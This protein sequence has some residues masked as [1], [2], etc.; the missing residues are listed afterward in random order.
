ML[1]DVQDLRIDYQVREG[2]IKSVDGVTL[3]LEKGLVTALI[4][5]SGSGKSTLSNAILRLLPPNG[6]I[7]PNSRVM[8]DGQNVLEM[9]AEGVRQFRW[10][11]ASLVFQAAQNALNPTV[12]IR[13]QLL[14]AV[15]DHGEAPNLER[16]A[17]LLAM[18]RLDPKRVLTAYPHELSGGMRQRV[19]IAMAL[20]MAPQ[21]VILD[22]PTTALDV[23]TQSC[24]FDI[25]QE[26]HAETG[27]T[28]LFITHDMAA[29]AKLADRIGVLYAGKLMELAP[30]E[31]LF[32]APRHPYTIGLLNSIPRVEGDTVLR[33][34]IEGQTPD[35]IHK[36]SGCVFH[37][38]CPHAVERCKVEVPLL[39][40]G[41]A[42]HLWR[43]L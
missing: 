8:F 3:S 20:M 26:I 32:E 7:D 34:P 25:L 19:I 23:I 39:D 21:L 16:L 24:I 9:S 14:D 10:R 28:M 42:C 43:D 30:A 33:K 41:V 40:D 12:P 11:Q 22:E 18:V 36:P 1:V 29:V 6:R 13:Q 15:E 38:R 2:L 5:E 31:R 17:R 35:L 27:L 4:G 37:P